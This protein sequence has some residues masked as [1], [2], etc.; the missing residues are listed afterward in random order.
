MYS[1]ILKKLKIRRYSKTFFSI[2]LIKKSVLPIFLVI[3]WNE[4]LA[5]RAP[6]FVDFLEL[7]SYKYTWSA[8]TCHFSKIAKSA[9]SLHPNLYAISNKIIC[10]H[11]KSRETIPL[12]NLLEFSLLIP[13]FEWKCTGYSKFDRKIQELFVLFRTLS[14]GTIYIEIKMLGLIHYVQI[15]PGSFTIR[16]YLQPTKG[17]CLILYLNIIC[18]ICQPSDC[19]VR[20]PGPVPRFEPR[21][22]IPVAG[23]LTPPRP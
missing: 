21:A 18:A 9:K 8:E 16:F 5:L 2:V 23:T 12:S 14:D 20:R 4:N 15:C 11:R 19:P 1:L 7:G 6:D 17:Q 22:V 3:F 13:L 10:S